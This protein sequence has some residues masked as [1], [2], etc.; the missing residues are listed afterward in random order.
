MLSCWKT[1]GRKTPANTWAEKENRK[2]KQKKKVNKKNSLCWLKDSE[3]IKLAGPKVHETR[4]RSRKGRITQKK[5][6]KGRE[7]ETRRSKEGRRKQKKKKLT[8]PGGAY[9]MACVKSLF[10]VSADPSPCVLCLMTCRHSRHTGLYSCSISCKQVCWADANALCCRAACPIRS[11]TALVLLC[12]P[13]RPARCLTV[14]G[15]L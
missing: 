1:L 12:K 6:Q 5:K 8:L 14:S 2:K 4:R 9:W 11:C 3:W 13:N 7:E 15:L 10:W